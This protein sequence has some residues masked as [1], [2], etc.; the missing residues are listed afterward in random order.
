MSNTENPSFLDYELN[1]RQ[2]LV[3]ASLCL[4]PLALRAASELETQEYPPGY[5]PLR[6]TV[7]MDFADK[8]SRHGRIE[9]SYVDAINRV[10][11]LTGQHYV[12]V[13]QLFWEFGQ[14]VFT[15]EVFKK[16]VIS[17]YPEYGLVAGGMLGFANHGK[18]VAQC[19]RNYAQTA[20]FYPVPAAIP[21]QDEI[22]I[23]DLHYQ[24]PLENPSILIQLPWAPFKNKLSYYPERSI[25]NLSLQGGIIAA[26]YKQHK[27]G[28]AYTDPESFRTPAF[29]QLPPEQQHDLLRRA[30]QVEEYETG[31]PYY[32]IQGAYTLEFGKENIQDLF[33]LVQ[34]F[35]E[36]LFVVSYLPMIGHKMSYLL[37]TG[38][39]K[40]NGQRCMAYTIPTGQISILML[41]IMEVNM[42]VVWLPRY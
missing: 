27:V 32:E 12:P 28:V 1:R 35:P 23:L 21:I 26:I 34:E 38:I 4:S 40:N 3:G 9:S 22:K 7:V 39:Q 33:E 24:D 36:K 16:K 14:N 13:A 20:G 19:H 17:A 42:G 5:I 29:A 2:L 41:S 30:I 15:E 31:A 6:N 8:Y 10:K 18:R 37:D 11:I 25:V